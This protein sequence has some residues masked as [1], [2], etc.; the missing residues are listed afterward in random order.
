MEGFYIDGDYAEK[1]N[2]N[3]SFLMCNEL[4]LASNYELIKILDAVQSHPEFR[5][6]VTRPLSI[7]ISLSIVHPCFV[8]T[9][10]PNPKSK[11]VSFIKK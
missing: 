3:N 5:K 10:D 7:S 4:V 9:S 2:G 6:I 1:E 11:F 8:P